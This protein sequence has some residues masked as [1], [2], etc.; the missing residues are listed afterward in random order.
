MSLSTILISRKT[1][2]CAVAGSLYSWHS[3]STLSVSGHFAAALQFLSSRAETPSHP[4]GL[5]WSRDSLW[6]MEC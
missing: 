6:A 1:G 3:P 2:V 4:F 5:S